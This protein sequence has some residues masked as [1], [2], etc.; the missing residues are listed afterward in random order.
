MPYHSLALLRSYFRWRPLF[1]P[2][3]PN[4]PS[5][6][7][8]SIKLVTEALRIIVHSRALYLLNIEAVLETVR[9]YDFSHYSKSESKSIA[10]QIENGF[11]FS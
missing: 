11:K 8:F 2:K 4:D 1:P 9:F 5:I 6:P 10:M 3:K 7:P